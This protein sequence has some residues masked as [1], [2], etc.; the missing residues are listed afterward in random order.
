MWYLPKVHCF[1]ILAFIKSFK[2]TPSFFIRFVDL[3]LLGSSGYL[4]MF[5]SSCDYTVHSFGRGYVRLPIS[6]R[7]TQLLIP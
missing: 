7:S 4:P 5:L 1:M 2:L 3:T 6:D